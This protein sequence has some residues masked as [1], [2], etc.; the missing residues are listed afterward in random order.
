[1]S[2]HNSKLDEIRVVILRGFENA[3]LLIHPEDNDV[4]TFT[5][6]RVWLKT[7]KGAR[8]TNIYSPNMPLQ[9]KPETDISF[10]TGQCVLTFQKDHSNP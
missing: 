3:T 7:I 5:L 8:E 4:W 2:R 1:M 10:L 9:R 6:S